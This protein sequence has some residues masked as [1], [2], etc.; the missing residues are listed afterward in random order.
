MCQIVVKNVKYVVLIQQYMV[1]VLLLF[2]FDYQVDFPK[3][4]KDY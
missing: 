2:M 1:M 3:R 4:K